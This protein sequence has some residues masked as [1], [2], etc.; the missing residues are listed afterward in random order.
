VRGG[1]VESLANKKSKLLQCRRRGTKVCHRLE[2]WHLSNL[3]EGSGDKAPAND[4]LKTS[5]GS[6][7]EGTRNS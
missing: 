2:M 3:P 5:G 7:T 6:V 4:R 1:G